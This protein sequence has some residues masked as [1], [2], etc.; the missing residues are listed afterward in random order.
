MPPVALKNIA[1]ITVVCIVAG[2]SLVA[3]AMQ[4]TPLGTT[5][6]QVTQ[7]TS[8]ATRP[9]ILPENQQG[10]AFLVFGD[11]EF[12]GA[13]GC[14]A[15]RGSVEWLDEGSALRFGDITSEQRDDT[16]CVPGDEDNANRIKQVLAGHDMAI[17]RPVDSTLRLQRKDGDEQPW[18][19]TP[20][21]E[22]I[23]GPSK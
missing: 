15:L 23:S 9:S 16:K 8:D 10:R 21:M 13:S 19:T 22:F 17:S 5:Q 4:E 12:T 2:L 7:I 6:W 14:I 3:C 1:H 11:R 20:A 18:Q